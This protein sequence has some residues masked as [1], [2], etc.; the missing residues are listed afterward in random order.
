MLNR[1]HFLRALAAVAAVI[2]FGRKAVAAKARETRC[3]TDPVKETL[4]RRN[5]VADAIVNGADKGDDS[6]VVLWEA[7]HEMRIDEHVSEVHTKNFRD[8]R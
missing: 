1:R 5:A 3:V 7:S 2:P 4:Q 6:L 8:Y